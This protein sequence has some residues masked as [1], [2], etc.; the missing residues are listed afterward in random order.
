M[1][2]TPRTAQKRYFATYP[3]GL[4]DIAIYELE[5]L[6]GVTVIEHFERY[7]AI[8]FKYASSSGSGERLPPLTCTTILEEISERNSFCFTEHVPVEVQ[9]KF[10]HTGCKG[11]HTFHNKKRV[12]VKHDQGVSLEPVRTAMQNFF[13]KPSMASNSN[14]RGSVASF[15][16]SIA[17]RRN[18]TASSREIENVSNAEKLSK[19]LMGIDGW[20]LNIQ[21]FGDQSWS[22]TG[23]VKVFDQ[24]FDAARADEDLLERLP[25]GKVDLKNPKLEVVVHVIRPN[26]SAAAKMCP[27]IAEC[28]SLLQDLWI[29]GIRR[30]DGDDSSNAN[31]FTESLTNLSTLPT[32]NRQVVANT[33]DGNFDDLCASK[34]Q[35][36]T[37]AALSLQILRKHIKIACKESNSKKRFGLTE[38]EI[39]FLDPMCGVGTIPIVWREMARRQIFASKSINSPTSDDSYH[40]QTSPPTCTFVGTELNEMGVRAANECVY[41][42]VNDGLKYLDVRFMQ[43]DTSKL[44]LPACSVDVIFVDP[45]WG[46]RHGSYSYVGKMWHKWHREW[47]RI[48]KPGGILSMVTIR[49]KH[50]LH[51]YEE[52]FR[53]QCVLVEKRLFNNA[54]FDNCCFFVFKKLE[55]PITSSVSSPQLG[56]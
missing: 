45:P 24:L 21:K 31:N 5:E 48:L 51:E 50:V 39:V 10:Q 53:K 2:N 41:Q 49:S 46:Q 55:L 15:D 8:L 32:P 16:S 37:A 34:T 20:K 1:G 28:D 52:C 18:S 12:V 22:S 29:F 35:L 11:K 27:D 30:R 42:N 40:H 7:N 47:L 25:P 4:G 9:Y 19:I 36:A 44:P 17:S 38:R 13:S 56:A 3:Q 54:G 6:L 14:R 26:Q 43:A 33:R 23:A